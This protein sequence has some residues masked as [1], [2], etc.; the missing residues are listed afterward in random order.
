M[1]AAATRAEPAAGTSG[2]KL[3][4]RRPTMAAMA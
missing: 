1:I 2:E 3:A 4:K